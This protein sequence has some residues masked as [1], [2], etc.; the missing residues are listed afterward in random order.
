M[1]IVTWLAKLLKLV[2]CKV[3]CNFKSQSPKKQSHAH[4]RFSIE[5][6]LISVKLENHKRAFDI[7]PHLLMTIHNIQ[8]CPRVRVFMGNPWETHGS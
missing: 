1:K 4:I 5:F 8:G 3:P 7:M 6:T 2:A